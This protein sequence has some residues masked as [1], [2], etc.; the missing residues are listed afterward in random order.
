[1]GVSVRLTSR[2]VSV[3]ATAFVGS[4]IS[5]VPFSKRTSGSALSVS[6]GSGSNRAALQVPSGRRVI[7]SVGRRK[8]TRVGLIWPLHKS[9]RSVGQ[10]RKH[11]S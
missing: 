11:S 4:K 3:Q 1:M 8:I 5:I 10:A 6:G 7:R 9:A 2:S